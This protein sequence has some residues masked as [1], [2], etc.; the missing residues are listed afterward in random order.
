[1]V[2]GRASA[3]VAEAFASIAN[4]GR[5]RGVGRDHLRSW[6]PPRR[7]SHE[8]R[9]L[10]AAPSV[11]SSRTE[12]GSR[13]TRAFPATRQRSWL[14]VG[15]STSARNPPSSS[16]SVRLRKRPSATARTV[17]CRAH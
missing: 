16:S 1:M 9:Q 2:F 3:L 10:L 12:T 4:V 6:S 11:T 8:P 7:R 17:H 13:V 15:R 5:A 14:D